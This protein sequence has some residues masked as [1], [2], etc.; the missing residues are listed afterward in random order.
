MTVTIVQRWTVSNIESA[1][2]NCKRAQ[3]LWKRHGAQGFRLSQI[4]TGPNSGQ[5]LTAMVF[6][7]IATYARAR[8]SA[9]ADPELQKITAQTKEEGSVMQEREILL[10]ID[11]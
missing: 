1:T 5:Y 7:D 8:A 11:L 4:F 10:G 9:F 6:S 3:A 2:E